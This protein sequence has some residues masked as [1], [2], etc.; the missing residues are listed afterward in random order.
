MENYLLY[1]AA[2]INALL[3]VGFAITS[4]RAGRHLLLNAFFHFAAAV[5]AVFFI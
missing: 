1:I 2:G 5:G 4:Y 3:C